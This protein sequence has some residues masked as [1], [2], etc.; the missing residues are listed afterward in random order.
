MITTQRVLLFLISATAALA[1]AS[2]S[3]AVTSVPTRA[4]MPHAVPPSAVENATS[5]IAYY[6]FETG[7]DGATATKILDSTTAHRNGTILTGGP[8]YSWGVPVTQVPST[9]QIDKFSMSFGTG[10]AARF[11]YEFPF[12]TLTNATLE[13]WVDPNLP[14]HEDDIFWTTTA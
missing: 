13:F 8:K 14:N 10:D 12:Q 7:P 11:A 9:D 4:S 3:A 1:T 5:T 2:C 6:R